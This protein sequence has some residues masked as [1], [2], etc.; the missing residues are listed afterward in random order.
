MAMKEKSLV[1]SRDLSLPADAVTQ[2]ISIL[3]KRGA[4]K[5]HTASILAE[6]FIKAGIPFV[7]LDP[8]GAW[9]GLRSGKD[10]KANGGY[11][12]YIIGGE[13]G[14]PLEYTAGKVIAEQVALH[15]SFYVIDLSHFG[16][17]KEQNHFVTDFAEALYRIKA[18]NRSPLHLFLDE[19]DAMAPQQPLP[20][21]QRMLGAFQAIVRRGRI[22]GIGIT[23]I[24]QRAASIN[25][26]V[27][28]QTECLVVLQTTSPQDQKA[29]EE[30]IKRNGTDEERRTVMQSLASLEKGVA[31]VWSPAWLE[32][33]KKVKIRDRLTYNSS[34]TPKMEAGGKFIGPDLKP[35]DLEKLGAQIKATIQKAEDNNPIKLQKRIRELELALTSRNSVNPE[36]EREL[37]RLQNSNEKILEE[38]R[39]LRAY[40]QELLTTLETASGILAKIP[41]YKRKETEAS[42]FLKIDLHSSKLTETQPIPPMERP[43]PAIEENRSERTLAKGEKSLLSA[44]VQWFPNGMTEGQ[45][46]THAGLRKSGTFSQYKRK[47]KVLQLLEERGGLIYATQKGIDE[48]G[49]VLPSPK[50]TEEVLAIWNPKLSDGARRMLNC[51]VQLRGESI[52][53]EELQLRAGLKKSGTYSQYKN[54]LRTANLATVNGKLISANRET[55]LL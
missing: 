41:I 55:L 8:T 1:L 14:I 4:G 52:S 42:A 23:L 54:Q 26:G 15:P 9:W 6:E 47:L 34:A 21:E 45:M 51:L 27:L 32:T 30:W 7:V 12:V 22:H 43:R 29:I 25:K 17:N 49:V 36:R 39:A 35:V 11:P 37:H 10:G 20:G 53:D 18:K 50:N 5:T 46:R 3:A 44:L 38:N 13:H 31:W 19:A 40:Q 28:T 16:S 2:T 48:L 33:L 24:S